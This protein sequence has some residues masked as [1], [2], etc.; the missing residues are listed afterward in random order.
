[1]RAISP[2][3]FQVRNVPRTASRALPLTPFS[4]DLDPV[5]R[6]VIF[7]GQQRENCSLI[8]VRLRSFGRNNMLRFVDLA[9]FQSESDNAKADNHW[10]SRDITR[11]DRFIRGRT[12][13]DEKITSSAF[14]EGGNIPSKFTCDGRTPACLCRSPVFLRKRKVFVL[15]A[16]DPDAPADCLLI[17]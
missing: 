17:G 16:D 8:W 15:I 6:P 14:Q 11:G 3:V 2:S 7:P 12:S 1:M 9:R 4:S 13:E 10:S 5:Q